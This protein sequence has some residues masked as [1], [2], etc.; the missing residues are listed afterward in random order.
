MSKPESTDVVVA[1]AG[2]ALPDFLAGEVMAGQ[3]FET[4]DKEAYAIPFL[5]VLQKTSPM[6]D[7]DDAAYVEGAR[8]GMILNTV[9]GELFD[10]KEGLIIIPCAFRRSFIRWGGREGSDPGFKGEFT[11]EEVDEMIKS[12]EIQKV[13]NM[14]LVPD[15]NGKVH[16]KK[17]DR[18]VDTRAHY[19]VVVAPDGSTCCAIMPLS[20]TQI[21]ASKALMMALSQKKIDTP[22]GKATPPTYA[23]MVKV[24]TI[25]QSNAKGSWSGI[26]FTLDGLV[27]DK[28]LFFMAKDFYNQV[29]SGEVSADYSKAPDASQGAEEE[30]EEG[31]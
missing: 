25:G 6:C 21:K 10:G 28:D 24:N 9:T 26:K 22:S 3:G 15:E 31:F 12:G 18:F 20:S 5:Q 14:M 2:A 7:P 16:E 19:V 29:N 4:A 11:P 17:S 1:N 27:T 13:E 8:P 23:N 30:V